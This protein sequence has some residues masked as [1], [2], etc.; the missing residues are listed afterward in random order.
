MEL[1]QITDLKELALF[2]PQLMKL[3][4]KLDGKW[5]PELTAHEF[6]GELISRF[7]SDNYYFGQLVD[8]K[9]TY[10]AAITRQS[11]T[12]ALFWLFFVN[13]EFRNETR[14]LLEE[15]KARMRAEGL[16][17]IYSQSTRTASSYE[18]WIRKLGATRVAIIYK[19]SI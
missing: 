14:G 18:R 19:F 9:L 1:H 8:D 12:K 7:G 6:L 15:L 10:F 17:T 4:S 13:P 11:E 16:T 5:E 2:T 3:Y